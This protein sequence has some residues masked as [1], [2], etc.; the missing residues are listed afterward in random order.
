MIKPPCNKCEKR[1][2]GCHGKCPGYQEYKEKQRAAWQ[3]ERD[4]RAF[5]HPDMYH[6]YSPYQPMHREKP[7][8]DKDIHD[9]K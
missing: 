8:V 7:F 5:E 3:K 4:M 6:G 1:T 2:P 9:E